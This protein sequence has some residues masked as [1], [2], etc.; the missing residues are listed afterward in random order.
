LLSLRPSQ[1]E[2]S[3]APAAQS[4]RIFLNYRAIQACDKRRMVRT[5]DILKVGDDGKTT[6]L[7]AALTLDAAM[8]RV[9][10]FAALQDAPIKSTA[11]LLESLFPLA[12]A[13]VTVHES[14]FF[15]PLNLVL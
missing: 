10:E 7:E 8:A 9:Q 1:K 14:E 12:W 2:N 11:T 6:F 15:H 3:G 4:K 5:F 13:V